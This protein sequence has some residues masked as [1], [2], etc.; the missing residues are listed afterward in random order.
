MAAREFLQL[1]QQVLGSPLLIVDWEQPLFYEGS[2]KTYES[3]YNQLQRWRGSQI[4][5]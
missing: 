2:D 4:R 5:C 3:Q 1:I